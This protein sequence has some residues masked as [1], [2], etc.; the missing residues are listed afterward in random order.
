MNRSLQHNSG[1]RIETNHE[2][3]EFQNSRICYCHTYMG[4]KHKSVEVRKPKCKPVTSVAS[5]RPRSLASPARRARSWIDG[6][7]GQTKI[8]VSP[9]TPRSTSPQNINF[10]EIALV[11]ARRLKRIKKTSFVKFGSDR[12]VG[13]WGER[14]VRVGHAKAP[15]LQFRL[16]GT[17]RSHDPCRQSR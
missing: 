7:A 10:R 13:I 1:Q 14:D 16:D 5:H 15:E 2:S 8:I 11:T 6:P 4:R 12:W 3:I 17:R 9:S